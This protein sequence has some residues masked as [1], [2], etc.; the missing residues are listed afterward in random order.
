MFRLFY[1]RAGV[2]VLCLCAKTCTLGTCTYLNIA[3]Y[4]PS[5][6][7]AILLPPP[8][9]HFLRP[10]FMFCVFFSTLCSLCLSVLLVSQRWIL[11]LCFCNLPPP[12]CLARADRWAVD[13]QER[14]GRKGAHSISVIDIAALCILSIAYQSLVY[15]PSSWPALIGCAS[16]CW[17]K[18]LWI[19]TPVKD[20]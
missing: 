5:I 14:G 20:W 12:L 16:I 7:H 4:H 15:Q 10:L 18:A 11:L 13:K 9:S 3:Y 6:P 8:A 19:M 17:E 1:S 2:S